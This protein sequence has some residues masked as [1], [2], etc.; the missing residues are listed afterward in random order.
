MKNEKDLIG[1]FKNNLSRNLSIYST[2]DEF[3]NEFILVEL[4]K[5]SCKYRYNAI[6]KL[7]VPDLEMMNNFS[8]YEEFK[9]INI[10]KNFQELE[11]LY[12][13]NNNE[14]VMKEEYK[15]IIWHSI[16]Q[17]GKIDDTDLNVRKAKLN[18]K[19][20]NKNSIYNIKYIHFKEKKFTH[21][22]RHYFTTIDSK[23]YM[24]R[25]L[26]KN[27]KFFFFHE[28]KKQVKRIN[29][30]EKIKVEK[31]AVKD[32]DNIKIMDIIDDNDVYLNI[33]LNKDL[34]Y[35]I[36]YIEQAKYELRQSSK[37][38]EINNELFYLTQKYN[39][40]YNNN[41]LGNLLFIFDCRLL[42][43]KYVT[44]I[45]KLKDFNYPIKTDTVKKYEKII[46]EL[47]IKQNFK[48]MIY[49]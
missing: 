46:N 13:V 5:L 36:K 24:K 48:N 1:F 20:N 42:K 19:I 15:N 18:Y 29:N 11:T 31:F 38:K 43:I 6:S 10:D 34:D 35:L 49:I 2:F 39:I 12:Y 22:I 17:S 27:E 16:K 45:E 32:M 41:L 8:I 7:K 9:P 26:Y 30:V 25:Y 47:I 21:S 33:D 14:I 23:L 3:K 37:C 4:F 40:N 44:I 28:F